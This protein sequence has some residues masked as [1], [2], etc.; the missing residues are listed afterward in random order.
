MISKVFGTHSVNVRVCPR[1]G[2]WRRHIEQL[3]PHYGAQEDADPG[4]ELPVGTMEPFLVPPNTEVVT[5][6]LE[7]QAPPIPAEEPRIP[8]QPKRQTYHN[9]RLPTGED[10]TRDNPRRSTRQHHAPTNPTV[11]GDFASQ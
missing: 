9:S 2:R 4:E 3:H 7:I 8:A 11:R 1:G 6:P 10:Y 5:F